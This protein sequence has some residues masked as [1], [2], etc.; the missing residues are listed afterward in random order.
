M[1]AITDGWEASYMHIYSQ[2]ARLSDWES[3]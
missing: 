3:M 1:Y 2:T